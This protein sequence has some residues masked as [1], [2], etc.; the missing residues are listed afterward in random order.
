MVLKEGYSWSDLRADLV[1]GLTVAV[2]A[3]PLSMALAIASGASP[4]KGL[5]TAVV[6]GFV[7]SLLGGSRVQIGGPTGAFVVVVSGVIATHGYA[8]LVTATLM[9]GAI[10]CLAAVL[11]LGRFVHLVPD[12]VIAG[13]TGGIAIVIAVSQLPDALGVHLATK[14]AEV[15]PKLEALSH[16]IGQAA[17]PTVAMTLCCILGIE[18]IKNRAPKLPSLLLVT[19][20]AA[21]V[22]FFLKLPVETIASRFGALPNTL[23]APQSPLLSP[24]ILIALLPSAASIAFLA[25]IESLLSAKVADSMTGGKHRSNAELLAQGVANIASALFGGLP[26]TGAIARTATN[27]KAG[28]KSPLAGVF[29]ALFVLAAMMLLGP[30]MGTAPLAALAGILLI[31]AWNMSEAHKLIATLKGPWTEAVVLFA[32]LIATITVNLTVA[33]ALGIGLHMVLSR[34]V[35]AVKAG[36]V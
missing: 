6:A 32:T 16:V 30:A 29:H 12:S 19:A 28:A 23:P 7:I 31:V 18:V 34:L 21:G 35:K 2:V 10:L 1:A 26:A 11:K 5:I 20:L 13:F 3:L 25:G 4:D 8:G 27:I 33:I 9:A 14:S 17:L 22:A 15:I 24:S 36:S